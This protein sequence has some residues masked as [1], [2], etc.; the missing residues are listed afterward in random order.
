MKKLAVL[1]LVVLI[2]IFLLNATRTVAIE[3]YTDITLALMVDHFNAQF[4]KLTKAEIDK[5][6]SLLPGKDFENGSLFINQFAAFCRVITA[7][8]AV[9]AER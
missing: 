3:R 9:I 7:V 1:L 8:D 4:A 5:V 6:A 2:G